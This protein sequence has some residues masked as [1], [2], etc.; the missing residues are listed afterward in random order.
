MHLVL[1][2]AY[3]LSA[4]IHASAVG[5]GIP[6]IA[7][8]R[9]TIRAFAGG[10]KRSL[11][12]HPTLPLPE[13]LMAPVYFRIIWFKFSQFH[14]GCDSMEYSMLCWGRLD[15]GACGGDHGDL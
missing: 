12:L 5:E 3:R 2:A 11:M 10:A 14:S 7:V 6:G 4:P 9:M 8:F 13:R 15:R 1:A